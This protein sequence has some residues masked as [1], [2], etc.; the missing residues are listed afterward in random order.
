MNN[1]P[2]VFF[3]NSAILSN[4]VIAHAIIRLVTTLTQQCQQLHHRHWRALL[5]ALSLCSLQPL[6]A[7]AASQTAPTTAANEQG[8][9]TQLKPISLMLDWFINPNH[10]P[11]I[12]AQQLGL[13]AKQGLK[14]NISEPADP[15]VPDKLVAAGKVDLAVSYPNTLIEAA[16]Q[17]LPLQQV[18]TLISTPLNA[19][20]VL[21]KSN[22]TSLSQLA[23]KT[24]G[25]SISGNEQASIDTMLQSAGVTPGSVKTVNV[26]WAL[27]AALASGRVDAIWGGQRNFELNQ[28]RL[29]G[30]PAH[31]FYPEEHGIPPFS[32]LIFVGKKPGL[33]ASV[34]AS[35]NRALEQATVFIINHPEKAWQLFQSYAPDTLNTEL[36]HKAWQDTLSHFARRPG[37]VSLARYNDYARFMAKHGI[38]SQVPAAHDYILQEQ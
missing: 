12:I 10:G 27:S 36:N 18:G 13:F 24:I 8:T 14:V 16:A 9:A 5:L 23:G 30:Y 3:A 19:L 25:V 33:P 7:L 34:I 20:I 6:S 21:D 17:H 11:I 1:P 37:A 22:I 31:A 32:E 26:G 15:S 2:S 28:L 4:R 35:F 29:E 38:I